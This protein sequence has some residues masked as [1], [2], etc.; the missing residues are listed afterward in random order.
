MKPNKN[1][2]AGLAI[3]ALSFLAGIY[4]WP[5][6]PGRVATHW[7]IHGQVN[8]YMPKFWGVFLMP[9]L[10]TFL[11][12]LFS[13]IP[14]IDPLKANIAKF[15]PHYDGFIIVFLL[16]MLSIHLQIILWNIGIKISPN[17]FIPVGIGVLWFY[18]GILF[19]NAKR[20]WFIGIRTPWTLSSE[21]VWDKTHKAG[22]LLFKI[23]GALAF[24]GVFFPGYALFLILIPIFS[25]DRR[26]KPSGYKMEGLC[27]N[28]G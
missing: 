3:I 7:D 13:A 15:K 25:V 11:G 27:P 6:L 18:I 22:S 28:L 5:Q 14:R 17:R 1:E 16:F 20:N 2:M 26:L 8:G 12:L 4:F 23:S 24:T 9:L 19:Q 21:R 10:I